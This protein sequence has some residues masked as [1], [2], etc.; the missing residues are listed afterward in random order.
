MK[1]TTRLLPLSQTAL[2]VFGYVASVCALDGLNW[3]AGPT[4]LGMYL[5]PVLSAVMAAFFAGALD[6]RMKWL[7]TYFVTVRLKHLA[8]AVLVAAFVF[9]GAAALFLAAGNHVFL[10]S[11]HANP[12]GF[13]AEIATRAVLAVDEECFHSGFELLVLM[14]LFRGR[15][16]IVLPLHALI[17]LTMHEPGMRPS[18]E[19]AYRLAAGGTLFALM[20]LYFRSAWPAVIAHACLNAVIVAAQQGAERFGPLFYFEPDDVFLKFQSALITLAVFCLA[21]ALHRRARGEPDARLDRAYAE[22]VEAGG[23]LRPRLAGLGR[24]G[25]RD[26]ASCAASSNECTTRSTLACTSRGSDPGSGST[27]ITPTN[28]AP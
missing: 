20:T 17:F 14:L 15:L 12:P 27:G 11:H 25:M 16:W 8:A 9:W 24:G 22:R 3:L 26:T 21:M 23:P 2:Y 6:A 10:A 19:A 5:V 4:R 28:T 1:L 7:R 13:V 18:W